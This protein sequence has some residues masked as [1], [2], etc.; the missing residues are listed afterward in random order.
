MNQDWFVNYFLVGKGIE[1]I[2]NL[3]HERKSKTVKIGLLQAPLQSV[4][5]NHLNF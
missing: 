1:L 2:M 4:L 5:C 3:I